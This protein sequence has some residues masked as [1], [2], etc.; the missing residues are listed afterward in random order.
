[1]MQTAGIELSQLV[2]ASA[3]A[4]GKIQNR[5]DQEQILTEPRLVIRI[6]VPWTHRRKQ[7]RIDLVLGLTLSY[8]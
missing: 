6:T 8:L 2:T 4:A 1:M 3:K 7:F 5:N